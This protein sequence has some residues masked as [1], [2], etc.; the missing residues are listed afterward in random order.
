MSPSK[1]D[2]FN[3]VLRVTAVLVSLFLVA[4]AQSKFRLIHTFSGYPD[5]YYHIDAAPI[6]DAEGNLYGSLWESALAISA[7]SDNLVEISNYV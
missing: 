1:L 7:R 2:G 5:R 6:T 3:Q 4:H